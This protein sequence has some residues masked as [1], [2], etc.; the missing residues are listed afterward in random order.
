M[1]KDAVDQEND[2]IVSRGALDVAAGGRRKIENAF[3]GG[4]I[5]KRK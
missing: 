1:V 3:A 5:L 2:I 4:A